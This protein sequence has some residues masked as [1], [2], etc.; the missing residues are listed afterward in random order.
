VTPRKPVACPVCD[1][2]FEWPGQLDGHIRRSHNETPEELLRLSLSPLEETQ[3]R[4]LVHQGHELR[5]TPYLLDASQAIVDWHEQTL[6]DRLERRAQAQR[7]ARR[8]AAL[9]DR[10]RR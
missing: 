10:R 3:L 1:R 9:N 7:S 6:P 5:E 8:R 4:R 2:R